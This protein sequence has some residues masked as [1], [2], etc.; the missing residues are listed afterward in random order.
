MK[1][2]E[3]FTAKTNELKAELKEAIKGTLYSKL[4]KGQDFCNIDES[5]CID[6]ENNVTALEDSGVISHINIDD[7]IVIYPEGSDLDPIDLDCIESIHD[8]MLLHYMAL[9]DLV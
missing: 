1:T 4:K 3:Y 5:N 7:N 2:R 6:F 9:N 8:L